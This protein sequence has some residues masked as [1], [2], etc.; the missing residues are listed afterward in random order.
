MPYAP[1][2]TQ[3]RSARQ[4]RAEDAVFA[5]E[6]AAA[7][8]DAALPAKTPPPA[9]WYPHPTMAG[10]RRYWDGQKWTDHIAPV[11]PVPVASKPTG[12]LTVARGVALGIGAV[13]GAVWFVNSLVTADDGLECEIDNADRAIQ[14]LP[15]RV[16]P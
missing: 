2:M 8:R 6:D 4:K 16:C 14:G 7:V 5:A 3:E 1:A 13:I 9:G 15:A 10:T 12:V 11:Q